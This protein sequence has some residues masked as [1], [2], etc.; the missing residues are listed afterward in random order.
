MVWVCRLNTLRK[1]LRSLYR[2]WLGI[3]LPLA[4]IAFRGGFLCILSGTPSWRGINRIGVASL[5]SVLEGLAYLAREDELP[6]LMK[7]VGFVDKKN[8]RFEYFHQ[9]PKQTYP[10]AKGVSTTIISF[11]VKN[12]TQTWLIYPKALS[13]YS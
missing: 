5:W 13:V 9:S 3:F 10:N 4:K 11:C 8:C 7:M 1:P 6:G 12:I 2:L